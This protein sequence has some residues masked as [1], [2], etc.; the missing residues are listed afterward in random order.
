MIKIESEIVKIKNTDEYI[1]NF[2]SNFNNFKDLFPPKVNDLKL[3]ADTCSFSLPGIPTMNLK[4]NNR[5][6]FKK[7]SMVADGGQIPFSLNCIIN[8]VTDSNCF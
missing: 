6:P 7:V 5:L 8:K 3:S 1:Y 4:I 2:I